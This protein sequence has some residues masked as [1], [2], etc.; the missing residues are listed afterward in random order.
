L[1][2]KQFTFSVRDC[3]SQR[4]K[5][6]QSRGKS[7]KWTGKWFCGFSNGAAKRLA[8]SHP[9]GVQAGA[10]RATSCMYAFKYWVFV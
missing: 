10:Q 1:W 2:N 6:S 5:L 4:E 7:N 9:F 8:L 3:L